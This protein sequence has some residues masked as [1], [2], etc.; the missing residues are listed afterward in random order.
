MSIVSFDAR[1]LFKKDGTLKSESY[2]KVILKSKES[3]LSLLMAEFFAKKV[4]V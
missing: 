4:E 1:S 2:G 3:A